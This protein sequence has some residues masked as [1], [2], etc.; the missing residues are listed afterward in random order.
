MKKTK[1]KILNDP[2]YGF[3][4]IPSELIY[5]IIE[6]PYFQ[7]LRRISQ[8][9]L[10]YLVFPGAHHTRFHHAIGAMHLMQ[11]A[12]RVLKRKNIKISEEEEEALLIAILLHDIGHG[13]FSHAL[14][15]SLV[16]NISHENISIQ[17]MHKLNRIFKN[18][19]SLAIKIF[20]NNYKKYLHQLISSQIDVDR[21]DYLNRDSFYS[22]VAEGIVNSTRIIDMYNVYKGQLVIDYK[23]LYT[24]EKFLLSRKLM[25]LQVYMHKTVLSAEHTLMNILKRAKYLTK[26]N[27]KIFTT[28]NLKKFLE[29]SIDMTNMNNLN[30]NLDYFSQLD[31][32]DILISIK[33]WQKNDDFILSTLSKQIIERKI[34]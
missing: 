30:K 22:G 14:E 26:K 5:K 8:L 25:Y 21:L 32:Y 16:R 9:G 29:D 12:V 33:E 18:R 17:Y 19:L 20:Q 2:I 3:I 6:H 31:D 4:T 27:H 7:R 1:N 11:K 15:H 28:N 34:T 24:A 10:S 13:P 23:G